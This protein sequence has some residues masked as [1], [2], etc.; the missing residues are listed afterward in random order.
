VIQVPGN[1]KPSL[2]IAFATKTLVGGQ[3]VS[4]MHVI[5]LGAQPGLC[6]LFLTHIV[7]KPFDEIRCQETTHQVS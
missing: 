1:E 6:L 7:L 5:E 3:L 4:K 2:V